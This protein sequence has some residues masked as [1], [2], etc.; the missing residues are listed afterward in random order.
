METRSCWGRVVFSSDQIQSLVVGVVTEVESRSL[1]QRVMSKQVSRAVQTSMS[2]KNFHQKYLYL[3]GCAATLLLSS[4][5]FCF[6]MLVIKL[7]SWPIQW[8]TTCSRENTRNE[9]W[10]IYVQVKG[11]GVG[12][13][14]DNL[15]VSQSECEEEVQGGAPQGR[16]RKDRMPPGRGSWRKVMRV[17]PWSQQ[18]GEILTLRFSP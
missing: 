15:L 17:T 5:L 7:T 12:R 6:V 14:M 11:F 4:F 10:V 3:L 9:C 18:W 1:E 13:T 16:E 2:E 8:A